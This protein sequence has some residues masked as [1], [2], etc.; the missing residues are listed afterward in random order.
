[1]GEGLRYGLASLLFGLDCHRPNDFRNGLDKQVEEV[2]QLDFAL[3][4]VAVHDPFVLSYEVDEAEYQ[5]DT[6]LKHGFFRVNVA[7]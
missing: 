5:V 7:Y 2:V 1:V 6:S 4:G 3:F